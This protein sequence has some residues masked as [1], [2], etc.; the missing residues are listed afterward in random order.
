MQFAVIL[1]SAVLLTWW[2]GKENIWFVDGGMI[3]FALGAIYVLGNVAV[4]LYYTREKRDEFNIILH[5]VFPV[6]SSVAVGIIWWESLHPFPV[7][8]FKWGPITTFVWA[9]IGVVIVAVL[10]L[11]GKEEWLAAAGRA[12][13]E[14]PETPEELAHRP[15]I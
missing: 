5:G 10:A 14:R 6:V 15:Q 13:E 9:G 7:A 11:M 3:T 4:L 8:P 12:A 2:W 1:I